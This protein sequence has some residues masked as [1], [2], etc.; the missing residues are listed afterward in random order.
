MAG[1]R[2]AS[3]W[4]D[5]RTGM[6]YLRVRVPPDM[7]PL[8]PGR[9]VA[10]PV[11][12]DS[13]TITVGK[14]FVKLSLATREPD[15]AKARFIAAQA[16]LQS[17]WDALRQGPQ[18]LTHK[19]RVALAGEVRRHVLGVYDDDPGDPAIWQDVQRVSA[20]IMTGTGLLPGR[21]AADVATPAEMAEYRY[22]KAL[23]GLLAERLMILASDGRPALI[24][25]VAR[26]ME[27]AAEVN[28]R[29]AEGDY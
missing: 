3:P 13:R 12:Q 17:F 27:E 15:E 11:G 16:A 24:E 18:P 14:N 1:I 6:L 10:L 4:K 22:G 26:A 23:D 7:L 5:K 29:R 8:A 28:L 2:M 20:Y 21:Q 25:A 19:Q 9:K